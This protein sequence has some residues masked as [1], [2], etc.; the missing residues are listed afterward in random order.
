MIRIE[1][2]DDDVLPGLPRTSGDDPNDLN[3]DEII[4]GF[5]PHKRG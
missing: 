4:R 1:T 3:R 2:A 5:A